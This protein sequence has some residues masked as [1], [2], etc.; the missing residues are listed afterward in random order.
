[1]NSLE[2]TKETHSEVGFFFE[3]KK[4]SRKRHTVGA[5]DL[6]KVWMKISGAV[7]LSVVIVLNFKNKWDGEG[8]VGKREE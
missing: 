7:H 8:E 3:K 4:K 5:G 2:W 6:V 1:M